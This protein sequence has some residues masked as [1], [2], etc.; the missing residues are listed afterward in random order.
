MSDQQYDYCLKIRASPWHALQ[1]CSR[2]FLCALAV[3]P[4]TCCP[5]L[6]LSPPIAP[7]CRC[8]AYPLQ[9]RAQSR[10]ALS[11]PLLT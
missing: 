8:P 6:C 10:K 7:Q 1:S 9:P 5:D 2:R 11:I 3:H 4:R